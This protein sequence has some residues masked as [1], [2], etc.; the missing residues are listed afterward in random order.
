MVKRGEMDDLQKM[1][2]GEARYDKQASPEATKTGFGYSWP[3]PRQDT[4]SKHVHRK[5]TNPYWNFL[6]HSQAL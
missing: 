4:R 6:T 5:E 1:T 3:S 2:S